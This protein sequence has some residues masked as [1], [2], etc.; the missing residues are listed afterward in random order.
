MNLR[1]KGLACLLGLGLCVAAL[2][3]P[4][5][6][7]LDYIV[8]VVNA[9]PITYKQLSSA[10]T[11][12]RQQLQQQGKPQPSP[13]ELQKDVLEQLINA[14][15]QIQAAADIGIKV[16]DATLDRAEQSV[17]AQNDMTLDAWHKKLVRDGTTVAEFRRGLKEQLTLDRLRERVVESAVRVTDVDVDQAVQQR[18]ATQTDPFVQDINLA[19][20]LVAVPEKATESEVARLFRKAQALRE[21]LQQGESFAQL[22]QAESDGDKR[23]AGAIGLRRADRYPALFVQATRSVAVGGFSEVVRSN[24]G[25]H[26]LQVLERQKPTSLVLFVTQTHVRHILLRPDAKLSQVDAVAKLAQLRTQLLSG[27]ADFAAQARAISQDGS[28]PDG[29]ELGWVPPGVFV[30]EFEAPMDALAINEISKPVVSRFGVH[31]IQVLDRQK[32]ELNPAQARES[33][34]ADLRRARQDEAYRTWAQD[35]RSRAFVEYKDL[36]LS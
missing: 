15:T 27:K 28:A 29:G 1:R 30:P 35:V 14:R 31:L 18:I 12:A 11:R 22:V 5:V 24:A 32:V 17:A 3:Q 26:I 8:A 36:D 2:A 10:M 7:T 9:E 34:R 21:R 6:Q 4:V 23:N 20:L 25:F 19:Q 33:V 16:D 13:K